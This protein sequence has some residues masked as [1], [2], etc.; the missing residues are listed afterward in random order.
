MNIG[1]RLSIL[2]TSC[3]LALSPAAFAQGTKPAP[4]T[5]KPPAKSAP[6][7]KKPVTPA[8][9][10]AA[11]PPPP[12]DLR[13]KTKYTAGDEVTDSSS[14]VAGQR[15]RYELGDIVLIT[16]RD[17]KRNIQISRIA[18]TY[19]IL[20]EE[21]PAPPVV[22]APH[23]P[24]VVN[25]NVSIVDLGERK[26]VFGQTARH[27]RTVIQRQPESG[28]CDQSKLLSETDGWYIDMPKALSSAPETPKTAA[29]PNGCTDEIK[30]TE[31]GDAKLLGFPL[32]YKT[33]LTDLGDKDAK[34]TETS[35]EVTEF[36]VLKLDASLFDI[37]A[38]AAAV[39]D[40]RE[41]SKAV[42]DA[43]EVKLAKGGADSGV[44]AKKPGTMRVGVP[45]VA[46]KTTQS[47]D[48]RALRTRIINELEEQ[49]IEAIPMAAASPGELDARAKELGVD[50][51][52]VAEITELKTS[53]PGGLTKV[54]KA[55][56]KEEARDITEAKLNMQLVAPGSKPRLSKSASGKD[57]GVGFKT[58]LKIAK[59]AGSVYMKFYMGGMLM[60]QLTA[61]SSLQQMNLG[62]MGTMG[63]MMPMGGGGADR[64]AGAA[65]FVMQQVVAG[66]SMGSQTGPS[67]DAALENAIEDGG[68]DV[69]DAIKKASATK[70]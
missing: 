21:A 38:G 46:N 40:A 39:N 60:G 10:A 57:G 58:T 33:T 22:A 52:V 42:S 12:T 68:K 63:S 4:K 8:V 59:F 31:S 25:V 35:M 66:A 53:K 27:V 6:A 34:P 48:T 64:T 1:V 41:F 13:F 20:P 15:E 19:V 49:K 54:M 14:F 5:Q 18:N 7:T 44:P 28:A 30:N 45:E 16:Q 43:N 61:M 47:V 32:S 69:V 2:I 65:S 56:A 50:Y 37:P 51:L 11:P 36:E 9:V 23:P 70:K 26:D 29:S 24:G 55:T 62:G 3:A 67:Y 17:Q